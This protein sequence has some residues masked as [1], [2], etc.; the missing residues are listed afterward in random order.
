[1]TARGPAVEDPPVD[2]V[3]VTLDIDWAPDCAIDWV[4]GQ[5]AAR[6]VRAT[7]FVTHVSPAVER[8]RERPD[9]F[10]LGIHP[11]FLPGSS[12]GATTDA[13]LDHC[14]ALVPEATS[15]RSH[16]LVQSTPILARIMERTPV[17]TDLSLFLAYAPGLRPVDFRVGERSLLRLPYFWED[18][19]EMQQPSPDWRL[20]P[21]LAVGAGLKVFDFHPVHVYM[22]GAGMA[23]YRRL[24]AG[25]GRLQDATEAEVCGLVR[26]GEGTRS[27]FLELVDHLA[28]GRESWTA[29][30]VAARFR[31]ARFQ[32]PRFRAAVTGADH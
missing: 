8:L 23:A 9:L 6:E 32:A 2:D 13:V 12:H 20:G 14:M 29:H 7:W 27:L 18:D 17:T 24:A 19:D 11:N 4:A 31:A 5:L 30:D 21:L 15:L 3:V 28:S 25:V 16:A 22:N 1:M 10:E 26:G